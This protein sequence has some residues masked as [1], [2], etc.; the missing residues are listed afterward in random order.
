[1]NISD[2]VYCV[3]CNLILT[4]GKADK[5]FKTGYFKR[6]IPLGHCMECACAESK[7]VTINIANNTHESYSDYALH[8]SLM[9]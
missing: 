9:A 4:R 7:K 8:L 1:M 2:M 3:E 5:I 6:T